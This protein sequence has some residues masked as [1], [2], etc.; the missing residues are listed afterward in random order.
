ML[1]SQNAI[2]E[3]PSTLLLSTLNCVMGQ[4]HFIQLPPSDEY[5]YVLVRIFMFS[6]WIKAFPCRQATASSM[7]KVLLERLIA[8]WESPFELHSD[9]GPH[10]AG[11]VL[12]EVCAIWPVLQHFHCAYYPSLQDQPNVPI[13][14]SKT[15]WQSL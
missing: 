6:H 9:G 3:N 14:S 11:Q 13:V 5:K 10:F 1:Y 2:Q 12:Q 8:T 15:S 4:M 7:V